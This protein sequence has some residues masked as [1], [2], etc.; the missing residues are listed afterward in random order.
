PLHT[1]NTLKE[2]VLHPFRR[3]PVRELAALDDLSFE[4]SKGEFFGVIGANGSGKST[5][6]KLL[7]GIYKPDLGDLTVQ[8]RL[9]P[10]I[11]LGVGF[12]GELA[13]RDNVLINCT[14]LGLSRSEALRRF[15]AIIEFA[16]LEDFVDL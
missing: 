5:L 1:P 3:I 14:L 6:L 7:A 2:R 15:D 8:G 16:E 12:N 13:A 11:E 10:F 9:S 4:I